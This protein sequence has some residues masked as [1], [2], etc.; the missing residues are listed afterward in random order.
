MI[1]L[2]TRPEAIKLYPVFQQLEDLNEPTF[3]LATAQHR[4]MLDQVL[5]IFPLRIDHDL[6]LMK[7]GQTPQEVLSRTLLKA[8]D[9]LDDISPRGIL[10]QGDTTTTLAMALAAYH[11]TIP[12]YHVEA[13]LRTTN[14]YVPF[15]EEM[16]RRLTSR[17]ASI[18]FPPT[19]WAKGNLLKEAVP[20]ESI[21]VTG[22]TVVDSLQ[23]ILDG[24]PEPVDP[25]VNELT[26]KGGR[27]ILVTCHRRESFGGPLRAI[28]RAIRSL[29]DQVPDLRFVYPVH[30]NPRV[31]EPVNELLTG[32][33][34]IHLVDPLPYLDFLV[35]MK[36]CH[37][38]LSDSGGVQE[39]APSLGKR[40]VL[41]RD[42]TERPEG[43]E[44]GV[45]V[46]AGTGQ[47][48]IIDAVKTTLY[49][50]EKNV[51]TAQ[52][53]TLAQGNP[54]GDGSAGKRIARFLALQERE[55]FVYGS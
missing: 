40:V 3:V 52:N 25:I 27:T 51:A 26:G 29:A 43:V 41:L 15:P 42:V 18:H 6:N 14:M 11:E 53:N 22:N 50:L 33:P 8:H 2:G 13:G 23:H 47:P 38:V 21:L 48:G 39:E 9:V 45:T 31:K 46:I 49:S 28:C 10:V 1:A 54:F 4:Q 30:P 16:N 20:K 55:E 36:R 32:H 37:L 34:R 35:L 17:L 19:T 12:V 5:Q 24:N 44:A 7:P